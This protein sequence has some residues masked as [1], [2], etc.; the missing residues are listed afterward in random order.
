MTK[1]ELREAGYMAGLN[2]QLCDAPTGT[3]LERAA[4]ESGWLRGK[5]ELQK[6]VQQLMTPETDKTEKLARRIVSLISEGNTKETFEADVAD[7]AVI[8]REFTASLVDHAYRLLKT[9][10][11]YLEDARQYAKS[12]NTVTGSLLAITSG[13]P[14][15]ATE[16]AVRSALQRIKIEEKQQKEIQK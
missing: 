15:W 7:V 10:P 2:S 12:N 6:A 3:A 13:S 16:S 8:L 9:N 11:T 5:S 1:D 14:R 4:W